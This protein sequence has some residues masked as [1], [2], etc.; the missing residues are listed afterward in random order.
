VL[1]DHLVY[2]TPDLDLGIAT[3]ER[4]LGVRATAGGRHP[5]AGTC[6]AL[7]ALGPG[8][9]LEIVGPDR[10]QP[11]PEQP[12]WFR[13]DEIDAP[14][15][16]T[17]AAKVD[18]IDQ[19][20]RKARRLGVGLGGIVAGSRRRD[21]GV[22]L[23]WR[24]TNPRTIVADGIIPFLIDWGTTPHPSESAAQGASLITL[25]AEHP[26]PEPIRDVA[27]RLGLSLQID[28]GSQPA[29]V[30][31]IASPRGEVELR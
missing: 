14:R 21:D 15:L 5:G 28:Q 25:R 17:W 1:I 22:V 2:A 29:L 9:Y 19:V 4:L 6:N 8:T 7:V 16:V 23:A 11:Q 26:Q 30:A 31:T 10:T 18:S 3:I 13:I 27:R 24:Y 20:S 12:R